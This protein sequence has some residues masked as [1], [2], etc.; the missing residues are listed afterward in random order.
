MS[1][2]RTDLAL[3]AFKIDGS[4]LEDLIDG[5]STIKSSGRETLTKDVVTNSYHF[6]GSIKSYTRYPERQIK[7]TY[8]IGDQDPESMKSKYLQLMRYLDT[9]D[10]EII[11]NDEPDKYLV[12]SFQAS[13][14]STKY[15]N[16][17]EGE[18]V[19]ICND[20]YKYSVEEYS[21]SPSADDAST[22]VI[23]YNGTAPSY[24]T[25]QC[26]FGSDSNSDCGYVAYVD[27]DGNVLQLGNPQETDGTGIGTLN[28]FNSSFKSSISSS[29]LANQTDWNT[30]YTQT[31]SFKI[32]NSALTVS[33]Y[34]TDTTHWH[35]PTLT[36]TVTAVTDWEA[37]FSS[38]FC[39]A[40]SK[41][42]KHYGYQRVWIADANNNCLAEARIRIK[43]SSGKAIIEMY[44]A[45]ELEYSK[46]V[47]GSYYNRYWGH[48]NKK[49]N[50]N[51]VARTS[52]ITKDGDT[53]TF[54]IAGIKK[55][56]DVSETI[57]TDA[58]SMNLSIGKC[59]SKSA[60][61]YNYIYYA[62]FSQLNATWD[63]DN[64]FNEEDVLVV[65]CNDGSIT[66]NDA[67]KPE[68]GALGN[69]YEKFTLENGQNQIGIDYSDFTT[70]APTFL[71]T[72]R[73]VFI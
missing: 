19:I 40:K 21:V 18:F 10:A 28:I 38:L 52:F 1:R 14:I 37:S 32:S 12:G 69:D 43:D 33:S 13:D 53:L 46:K 26:T 59:K 48:K 47:S 72:Y 49:K 16:V 67:P 35:G 57:T 27:E 56:F 68:L 55:S 3:D 7:I 15:A 5:Y 66:L 2:E 44:V 62:K 25:I 22:F 17:C 31:G 45:G 65:D 60:L 42:T 63:N 20:P 29:W 23:D 70:T 61:P 8:V 64:T 24:P 73:E 11:F 9:E 4:Y 30:D 39:L 54:N 50:K 51:K 36:Q 58:T 41:W 34:G 6:D 71:L